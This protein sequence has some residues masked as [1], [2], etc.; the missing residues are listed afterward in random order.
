MIIMRKIFVL[1]T[2]VAVLLGPAAARAQQVEKMDVPGV[3]NFA[4]LQ[5]TIACGGAT[6]PQGVSEIKKMGFAAIINLREAS[7]NGANI[8]EEAA[9]AKQAGINFVHLPFNAQKPDPAIIDGFLKAVTAPENQPAFVHCASGNR[10]AA[11]WLI[12]RID[13][14]GWDND[15]ASEEAASLGLTSSML[16]TFALNYAAEHKK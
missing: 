16:K 7:E 8:D 3:R 13:V 10:A 4:R 9:A 6:T 15:R 11:L 12:K 14:D 1:A 5:T 2:A